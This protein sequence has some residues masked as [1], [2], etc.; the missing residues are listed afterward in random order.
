MQRHEALRTTFEIKDGETVQRI[1]EEAECEIAYFEAPK[2]RQSGSFL[3]L[4]SLS[5]S[6]NFHCS[7]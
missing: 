4:L 5:K 6:T 7:E 1:W 3:S 2:K